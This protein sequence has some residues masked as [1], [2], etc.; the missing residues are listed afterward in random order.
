MHSDASRPGI[1]HGVSKLCEHSAVVSG[2]VIS[3]DGSIIAF[4]DGRQ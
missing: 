4:D 1:G 3:R 2:V